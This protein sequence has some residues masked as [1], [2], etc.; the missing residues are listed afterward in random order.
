MA[1]ETRIEEQGIVV[2]AD[3]LAAVVEVYRRLLSRD[4]VLVV[5]EERPPKDLDV[6]VTF[7][8]ADGTPLIEARGLVA[9]SRPTSADGPGGIGLHF[10]T[11]SE[12]SQQLIDRMVEHLIED[13]GTPF[14][15]DDAAPASDDAAASGESAE[16]AF[17]FEVPGVSEPDEREDLAGWLVAEQVLDAGPEPAIKASEGLE[18]FDGLDGLDEIAPPLIAPGMPR[19]QEGTIDTTRSAVFQLLDSQPEPDEDPLPMVIPE[20]APP[21]RDP[22]SDFKTQLVVLPD[23][24]ALGRQAR[25]AASGPVPPPVPPPTHEPVAASI[26]SEDPTVMIDVGSFRSSLDSPSAGPPAPSPLELEV[27]L[28]NEVRHGIEIPASPAPRQAAPR[29]AVPQTASEDPWIEAAERERRRRER[30]GPLLVWAVEVV[31]LGLLAAV[32]VFR[33]FFG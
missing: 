17:H 12:S 10:L 16:P 11:L 15:V 13:G 18:G 1:I 31:V 2:V 22:S 4:G 5:T 6:A 14:V 23:L 19:R 3:D 29:T 9:W 33:G 7:R 8:L 32:S 27:T 24:E 28:A 20:P 30:L 21:V 26:G 25:E